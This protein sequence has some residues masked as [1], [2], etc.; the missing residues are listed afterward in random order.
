MKKILSTLALVLFSLST[1]AQETIGL[2]LTTSPEIN[3]D[4]SITFRYYA[5]NAKDVQL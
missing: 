3:K 5:P 1:T 2:Q 4:G